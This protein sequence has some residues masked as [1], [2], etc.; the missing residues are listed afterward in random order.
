[1]PAR[2]LVVC[3]VVAGWVLVGSQLPPAVDWLVL[4]SIAAVLVG[5]LAR[6]NSRVRAELGALL[7]V[8]GLQAC[9]GTGDGG[10]TCGVPAAVG[11]CVSAATACWDAVGRV[12]D[13]CASGDTDT[14]GP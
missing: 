2:L 12:Q 11:V 1:M 7:A 14:D 9:T 5:E 13:Q 6:S 3:L 8:L 10:A 4:V